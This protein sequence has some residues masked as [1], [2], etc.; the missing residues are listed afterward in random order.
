MGSMRADEPEPHVCEPPGRLAFQAHQA[1]DPIEWRGWTSR[2]IEIQEKGQGFLVLSASDSLRNNQ[3]S[4][5]L[6]SRH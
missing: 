1:G 2:N 5:F 4:E 6:K 3:K